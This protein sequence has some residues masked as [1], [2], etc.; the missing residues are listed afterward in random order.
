MVFVLDLKRIILNV[1]F[2]QTIIKIDTEGCE[3]EILDSIKTFFNQLQVI[4]L[5]FH[6][7]KDRIR[8]YS[9][10]G[11]NGCI[12]TAGGNVYALCI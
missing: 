4:Y 8:I 7:E 12:C 3:L 9:H 10:D 1:Y 6:S 5:E 11:Y 2:H